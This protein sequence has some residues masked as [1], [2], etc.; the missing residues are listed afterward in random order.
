RL[1]DMLGAPA[2]DRRQAAAVALSRW[3]EPEA[4]LAVLRAYLRG[5]VDLPLG[6]VPARVLP[7]VN[8]AELRADGIL[9]DRVALVAARLEAEELEPLVPLLL[10]WWEN[11]PPS[12]SSAA[13]RAL[14][15]VPADVLAEQLGERLD[16][17][18]WGCLDLLL[19]RPLLRTSAL[20]R[21]RRR[22]RAEG[23][24]DLAGRLLLVEG[25]LRRPDAAR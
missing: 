24:E 13:G 3:P 5:R 23:R 2:P 25:P 21:V 20:S 18:A 19:G 11:D 10:E 17:G 12:G 15:A 7:A 6:A 4:R 1:L 22:L 16:A 9:H 14:R 8:A